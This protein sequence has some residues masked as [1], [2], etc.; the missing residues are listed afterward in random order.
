VKRKSKFTRAAF[1]LVELLVVIAIIGMLV[2]LLLPAVNAAREAGRR[3]TCQ[4]NIRNIAL[5]LKNYDSNR[6]TLPAL[7]NFKI[8][9]VDP[10]LNLSRPLL[11]E[12]LPQLERNDLYEANSR[13]RVLDHIPPTLGAVPGPTLVF[14]GVTVCP[15][16]PQQVGPVTAFAYNYGFAMDGVSRNNNKANGIFGP[17]SSAASNTSTPLSY[18]NSADGETN[19]IILAENMDAANWSDTDPLYV[20]FCWQDLGSSPYP[21]WATIAINRFKGTSGSSANLTGGTN[22]AGFNYCRP[23]AN[24]PQ[25]AN[26]AFCDA[27]VRTVNEAIDP[28]VWAALMAPKHSQATAANGSTSS[29]FM[30]ALRLYVYDESHVPH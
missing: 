2:S 14:M 10:T 22:P 20:S 7:A 16:D 24:H 4:N 25:A 26:V 27:H 21:L 19:T 28:V 1:T 17:V 6:N 11:Y 12:I 18:V 5:A 23:S 3:T 29:Q 30:T 13:E 9:Q 8:S 15:S